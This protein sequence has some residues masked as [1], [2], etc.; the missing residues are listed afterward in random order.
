MLYEFIFFYHYL[1]FFTFCFFIAIDKK[2]FPTIVSFYCD[3]IMRLEKKN[4]PAKIELKEDV[5]KKL[6]N[7]IK[8]IFYVWLSI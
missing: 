3:K 7:Y 6:K 1:H 8:M 4:E 5:I 2:I